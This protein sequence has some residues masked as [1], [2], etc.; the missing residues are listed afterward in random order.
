MTEAEILAEPAWVVSAY[1]SST[2]YGF[3]GKI[4]ATDTTAGTL[5][6]DVKKATKNGKTV[7]AGLGTTTVTFT[8]GTNTAITRNGKKVALADLQVGDLAAVGIRAGK[9]ATPQ[10]VVGTPASSV[11]ALSKSK[12]ATTSAMKWAA[13]AASKAKK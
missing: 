3:A 6:V 5:T 11:L 13:R 2:S 9:S 12:S 7:L 8:T 1:S 10:E 4:T